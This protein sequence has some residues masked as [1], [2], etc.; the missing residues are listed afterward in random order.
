MPV[1][2]LGRDW[3]AGILSR[4]SCCSARVWLLPARSGVQRTV[5]WGFSR[6]NWIVRVCVWRCEAPF[7]LRAEGEC[8]RLPSC[9]NILG[10]PSG[11]LLGARRLARCSVGTIIAWVIL[12]VAYAC[13]KD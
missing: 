6:G 2:V 8:P 9:V 11:G 13:L 5:P 1:T 10:L 12:L 7:S 4:N 3:A